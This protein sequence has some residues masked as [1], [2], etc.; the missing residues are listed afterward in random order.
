MVRINEAE[1]RATQAKV[2]KI[3]DRA[4]KRGFTGSFTLT[5]ELVKVTTTDEFGFERTDVWHDVTLTGEAPSYN[6]WTFMA[7]LDWDAAAGLIVRTAPGVELVDRTNLK[8]EWCDHC[9]TNRYRKATYVVRNDETGEQLQVGSTCMKDFL[10]WTAGIVFLSVD[11]V[12]QELGF[13]SFSHV[14]DYVDTRYALAVAWAL[15]TVNGF[16]PSSS[17]G[18]TTKGDVLD[19]C[20]P[21]RGLSPQR[22]AELATIRELAAEAMARADECRQW[23]LSDQFAGKNDYVLNL[24]A[25][26]GGEYVSM[27]NIGLL[28]SAPQAWARWQNDTLIREAEKEQVSEWI[29]KVGDKVT[30]TGTIRAINFLDG[31]QYGTVTLYTLRDVDGNIVKWF[32]S[33]AALGEKTGEQVTLTAKVKDLATYKDIKQT[34][35][36]RAKLVTA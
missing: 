7:T 26:V 11:E 27:R 19:V 3:N 32:A 21:P 2:K 33:R 31:G 8:E 9:K 12:T 30:F 6:G 15:I 36:T 1:L 25:V 18:R 20:W 24:K 28:A 10:G 14:S 29:G 23:I 17:F 22:R 13:G 35:V 16:Q 5:S 4:I 34:V